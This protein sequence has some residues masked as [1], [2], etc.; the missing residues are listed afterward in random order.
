MYNKKIIAKIILKSPNDLIYLMIIL[1]KIININIS[2]PCLVGLS[3]YI[4][5]GKTKIIKN[6]VKLMG[7]WYKKLF[8]SPSFNIINK[9]TNSLLYHIDC[10]RIE[11]IHPSKLFC[12]ID[13]MN[14]KYGFFF[15]NGFPKFQM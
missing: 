9:Y 14:K 15:L 1:K 5:V 4:G 13:L 7:N 8:H 3:G 12:T 10:C 2:S 11:N 6:F